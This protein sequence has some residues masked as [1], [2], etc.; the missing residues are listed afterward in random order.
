ME[1]QA[2]FL[3]AGMYSVSIAMVNTGLA[4][5]VGQMVINLVTPFGPLGLAAG[6]YL[7]TAALTQVMGGQVATLVTAPIVIS[8]AIT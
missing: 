1:W 7:L 4:A 2:I 3:I 5:V 8:A 6:A